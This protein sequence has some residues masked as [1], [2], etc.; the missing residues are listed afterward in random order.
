[1]DTLTS[2]PN[3]DNPSLRF[4]S[5]SVLSLNLTIRALLYVLKNSKNISNNNEIDYPCHISNLNWN[6]SLAV[7]D[8]K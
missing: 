1:M 2:Q 7:Y 5:Q 8:N 6:K 4:S 3:A